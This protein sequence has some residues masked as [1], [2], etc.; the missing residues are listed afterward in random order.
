MRI[1]GLAVIHAALLTPAWSHPSMLPP[2]VHD[3][4]IADHHWNRPLR[5]PPEPTKNQD[6]AWE[7]HRFGLELSNAGWLSRA[8]IP[9]EKATD[10][11]PENGEYHLSLGLLYIDLDREN[12]G[13]ASLEKAYKFGTGEIKAQAAYEL[14]YIGVI[15]PT[16]QKSPVTSGKESDPRS[17]KERDE[18]LWRE[19]VAE[20]IGWRNYEYGK[21]LADDG[22]LSRSVGPLSRAIEL[23]PEQGV[24]YLTRGSV[25]LDL[26]NQDDAVKDFIEAYKKGNSGIR[27]EAA[28]ILTSLNVELPKL[29]KV[30]TVIEETEII[31]LPP[32]RRPRLIT[33]ESS[34]GSVGTVSEDE[35]AATGDPLYMRLGGRAAIE[36][37]VDEFL[38]RVAKNDVIK[39]R[40][41]NTNLVNLKTQLV[42]Q[43]G[44]ASGGPEVYQGGNMKAVH[45]G[46]GIKSSEFNALVDDLV[47]AMKKLAV[48]RKEQVELLGK[49]SAMKGDIVEID[50]TTRGSND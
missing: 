8:V 45:T 3:E 19:Q 29:P 28:Y 47:G 46:M 37:V 31:P 21:L 32:A 12:D 11:D 23:Q 22:W 33:E 20:T 43:I 10:L 1:L 50:D 35:S 15:V 7:H 16:D 6:A 2:H 27:G 17:A 14:A 26:G 34:S 49:L 42:D 39:D 24:F 4:P 40:F 36:A 30:T 13:V 25:R 9:L 44:Q 18:Q 5:A 38:A 41:A 48:P